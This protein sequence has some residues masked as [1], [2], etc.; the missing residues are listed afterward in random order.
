MKI[1]VSKNRGFCNGVTNA[2]NYALK[3]IET[4]KENQNVY[5]YGE[6]VHNKTVINNLNQ[7]GLKI[8]DDLSVLNKGDVL[9]IRSHGAPPS[10]F[11]Y[12]KNKGVNVIDATCPFV[13]NIQTKARDYFAK[14]YH[15]V[16]VGDINHPEIIGINGWCNN[17]ATIF[18]GKGKLYLDTQK[19]VLVLFQTT[20]DIEKV[21]ETLNNIVKINVK[22]LEFFNTICYTTKS[23]Q[24]FAEYA[25]A[26]SDFCV[27]V[28][29]KHSSNTAKLFSIAKANNANTVWIENVSQLPDISKTE[30]IGLIAGASTPIEL[31]EEVLSKMIQDAKDNAVVLE[32]NDQMLEQTNAQ[33]AEQ[34]AQLEPETD[35]DLFTKAIEK[36]DRG[37]RQFKKGQKVKGEVVQIAQDGV[38]VSL[39]TK[40]EAIIPNDQLSL[41]DDYEAVKASLNIGDKVECLVISTDKGVTLSKKDIDELYKDD[42]Q[43]EGIKQGNRFEVSIKSDVKGGLL[44][45]LGNYTIFVPASHIKIGFVND[46]KQYVGK[47][48]TLVALPDGIDEA[49]RKIVASHKIILEQE[50]QEREDNFWNNIEVGEIVEGKVLRYAA[51]GVFV[52]VRGMDCLAHLSDLSWTPIKSAEEVLEIGKTYEFVVLKLDRESNRISIGYK[53]LQPHPWQ[54]ASEKYAAGTVVTGKVA[55]ILPYG[56]FIELGD[57]ID[58]LLHISNISWDWLADINKAVK[59][60]DELELQVIECDAENKRI[61]LSRKAL[62]TPPETPVE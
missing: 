47:K 33:V 50:K 62:I 42:E 27:V 11:D 60:G 15:I 24:L 9:I 22:I 29:G 40:K 7:K 10:V 18:D 34:T 20:Y 6:I 36:L 30:S 54:I 23:R 52:N 55:R 25:S 21:E 17:T 28:G 38:Y 1:I 61:T 2:V 49:K 12:C 57:N 39:G 4:K 56:A 43:V 26:N 45:K 31:T 46:L 51:F 13:K 53:Q 5:S 3:A 19:K 16:L 44:A 37:P 35:Q 59:V 32:Q 8:I 58:G 48:M 41:D 14:G